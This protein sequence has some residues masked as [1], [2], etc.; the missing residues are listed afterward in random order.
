VF[1]RNSKLLVLEALRDT[2]VVFVSGPRQVGKTTIAKQLMVDGNPGEWTYLTL[3]DQAQLEIAKSDPVGFIRGL[4]ATRIILD[5]V[6]RAPELFVSIK[7]SVDEKRHNGRFLLTGSTNALLLPHLSGSLTGRMETVPLLPL[8]E[9]EIQNTK[10]TFL[11]KV[12]DGQPPSASEVRIRDRVAERL[13]TGCFPEPLSRSSE[14]RIHAWYQQYIDTIIHGDILDITE[15]DYPELMTRLLKKMAISSGK[16]LN[17]SNLG[18]QLDLNLVTIKKYIGLLEKMYLI[19]R[20]PAWHSNESKRLVKTAKVFLI[21]SGLNCAIRNLN[22]EKLLLNPE[23]FGNLVESF[24]YS[25][26]R[27][28]AV[29]L[30]ERVSFFHF[31]DKD[32]VEVDLILENSLGDCF[33]IETKATASLRSQDFS[34]LK[35]FRNIA[36]PKFRMGILLYDGDHTTAFG[37]NLFAAPIGALWA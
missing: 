26:L 36:G 19:E 2:P 17:L 12:I 3:D 23:Q 37:D 11:R 34:G 30:S 8:S 7:Q 6:Q 5:E 9:C 25:E 29:W 24:V 16:L 22:R 31:R 27:K 28:Q 33:A 13:V 14:K 35:R 10:P 15:I 1:H 32:R 21:D 4:P 18:N 20:V